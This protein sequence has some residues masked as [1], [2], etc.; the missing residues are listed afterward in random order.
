MKEVCDCFCSHGVLLQRGGILF[1]SGFQSAGLVSLDIMP[2]TKAGLE[3][4]GLCSSAAE[5]VL[6]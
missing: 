2:D 3:Q 5:C 1:D 6:C 4:P